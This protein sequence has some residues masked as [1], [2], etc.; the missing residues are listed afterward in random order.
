MPLQQTTEVGP[1]NQ[2]I[3]ATP[4]PQLASQSITQPALPT[5]TSG[6]AQGATEA[7][8][9]S[10]NPDGDNVDCKDEDETT[11]A[12]EAIAVSAI[13]LSFHLSSS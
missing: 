2:A 12:T 8:K 13:N 9:A 4:S 5:T 6:I 10:D 3:E 11:H 1:F 7:S